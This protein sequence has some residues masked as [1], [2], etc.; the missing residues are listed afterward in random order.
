MTVIVAGTDTAEGAA[1]HAYGIE[2]A[3]R[4]GED[5]VH[6]LLSGPRPDTA[7]AAEAG[8]RLTVEEPDSRDHD[9]S[10]A[11]MDAANRHGASAIVV[12][13]RH[14]SPVGKLLLGSV[15]QHIILQAT[16]PVICV[17]SESTD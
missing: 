14:R 12:G 4:R 15:A 8:V 11:L 13:V 6:F 1:A 2:E 17:K 9:P 3:A 10:G 16:V 5:L 7:P